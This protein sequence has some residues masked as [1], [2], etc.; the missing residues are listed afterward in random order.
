MVLWPLLLELNSCQVDRSLGCTRGILENGG[1]L[2]FSKWAPCLCGAPCL[3]IGF[4]C[5]RSGVRGA[6]CLQP[7]TLMQP[8]AFKVEVMQ[9]RK[10]EINTLRVQVPNY[11]ASTQNRNYYSSYGNPIYP[12]VRYFG[13]L[14]SR[15]L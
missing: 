10:A 11:K 15:D 3:A 9:H 6:R 12:I 1:Y 5:M 8:C 13:P 4:V 2:G 14:G 7:L